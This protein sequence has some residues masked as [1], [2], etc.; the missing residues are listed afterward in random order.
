MWKPQRLLEKNHEVRC[1]G[2]IFVRENPNAN[3][4]NLFSLLMKKVV[5][6]IQWEES[7]SWIMILSYAVICI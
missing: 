4:Q 5:L 3:M 2:P 7:E 1:K 6:L